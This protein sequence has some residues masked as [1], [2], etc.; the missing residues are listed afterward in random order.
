MENYS[1]SLSE[2]SK[3]YNIDKSVLKKIIKKISKKTKKKKAKAKSKVKSQSIKFSNKK[4]QQDNQI[5]YSYGSEKQP[6]DTE[7]SQLQTVIKNSGM[8]PRD[9]AIIYDKIKDLSLQNKLLIT[10]VVPN[11][12]NTSKTE[13]KELINKMGSRVD[14]LAG[15]ASQKI[16]YLWDAVGDWDNN[17]SLTKPIQVQISNKKSLAEI[18]TTFS[19]RTGKSKGTNN[20]VEEVDEY[21]EENVEENPAFYY[22]RPDVITKDDLNISDVQEEE[23]QDITKVIVPP[24]V[25]D[26]QEDEDE[27]DEEEEDEEEVKPKQKKD[28]EFDPPTGF[29]VPIQKRGEDI[30]QYGFR[31]QYYIKKFNNE[32]VTKS[33]EKK[34]RTG[35]LQYLKQLK[36]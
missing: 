3:L 31:V 32:P 20:R 30:R 1:V 29:T 16:N 2:L 5:T 10:D 7:R 15:D 28:Y 14:T 25:E 9:V 17:N 8:D 13:S 4:P 23:K 26:V 35:Y 19:I 22:Y 33:S 11:L 6:K 18:P 27:E 12:V 36:L 24:I 34:Y 21:V